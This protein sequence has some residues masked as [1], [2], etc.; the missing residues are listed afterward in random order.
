[1]NLTIAQLTLRSLLGRRRVWLL[2]PLPAVLV[3]LAALGHWSSPDNTDWVAPVVHGLGLSVVVPI[4]AL[5]IGAS[6]VGSEIDD[7]TLVHLLTK[8]LPRR[9][10]LLAKLVVAIGVTAV[11]AG[12]SMLLAG[13][14]ADSA[15][16]GVGLAAGTVV[17]SA[18]YCALFV[19]LSVVSRR[20]VLIGLA[21]ILLWEGLLTNLL[22]GTRS[23]AVQQYAV[24]VAT[25]IAGPD[26]LGPSVSFPTAVVM[27]AVFVVGGT[28]LAIDRLR[29]FTVAG[30]TS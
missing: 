19:A 1:M 23:L 18:A 11:V 29:S 5:I 8:P 7:G 24:S 12:V 20:P 10:I 30:E 9:E 25:K 17:A 3:G 22:T 16:F 28:A 21:Y 26:I 14:L 4:L 27:A 2:V 15:R 13:W 6:V